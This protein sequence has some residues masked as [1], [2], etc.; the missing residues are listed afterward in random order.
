MRLG[1]LRQHAEL[2]LLVQW[3]ILLVVLRSA[4]GDAT[5]V[6]KQVAQISPAHTTV[7]K[8]EGEHTCVAVNFVAVVLAVSCARKDPR[9]LRLFHARGMTLVICISS[10]SFS[11]SSCQYTYSYRMCLSKRVHRHS[12]RYLAK[13]ISCAGSEPLL[14]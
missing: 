4:E 5:V 1:R 3:S 2:C 6:F 13:E 14:E 11:T 7:S 12:S 9:N 8:G 10:I